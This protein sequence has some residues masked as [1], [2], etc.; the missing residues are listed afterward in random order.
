MKLPYSNILEPDLK[1]SFDV[2]GDVHGCYEELVL[3]I[4]KLGY[5]LARAAAG[6]KLDHPENRKLGFVG[7]LVDRGPRNAECLALVMDL[8]EAGSAICVPGNHDDKLRRALLGRKVQIGEALAHTLEQVRARGAQFVQRTLDFL[9]ALPYHQ[10]VDDGRLALVHAALPQKFIG[11]PITDKSRART[12]YGE[13]TGKT[14]ANGYPERLDWTRKYA[15]KP[16]VVYGHTPVFQPYQNNHTV[17]VDTGCVFGNRLTA[18]RYP[19]AE[20]VSVEALDLYSARKGFL[21]KSSK[22]STK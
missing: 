4:E 19:E 13:T 14:D 15:G 10:V 16:L 5:H 18:L 22:I 12:L 17:N 1:G 2:I 20:F 7:D 21:Q 9:T 3:L 11:T 8:V 6:Y